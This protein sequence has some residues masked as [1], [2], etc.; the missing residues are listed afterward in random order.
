MVGEEETVVGDGD[1]AT[2]SLAL[3]ANLAEVIRVVFCG[4]LHATS[5]PAFCLGFLCM[6]AVVSG[7]LDC[8]AE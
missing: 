7:Q 6:I 1:A 8:V 2:K 5:V 3:E 4:V